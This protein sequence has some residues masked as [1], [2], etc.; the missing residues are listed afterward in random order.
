MKPATVNRMTGCVIAALNLAAD[1]DRR[2]QNRQDWQ[3]GLQA[4][5]DAN[6]ARNVILTDAQVGAFVSAAYARNTKLGELVHVLAETG[7]R[8]SQAAR[9]LVSDLIADPHRPKL[10]MPRSG[11]GGGRNRIR[12]KVER[13]NVA[14]TPSLCA[15][16]KAGAIG[17]GPNEP[18]LLQSDGRPWGNAPSAYYDDDIREVVK[19]IGLDPREV[20]AYSLRHSSICRQLIRRVPTRIVAANHDTSVTYVEANYS[21]YIGDHDHADEMTRAA[22]PD[23]SE[24]VGANVVPLVAR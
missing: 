24:P 7:T 11:K 21:R 14:I 18:L 10:A 17:R 13:I 4:L 22:L 1:H 19:A 16:L 3:T 20:T 12:R 6:E 8:P 5:P 2:I 15:T 23:H 9:L